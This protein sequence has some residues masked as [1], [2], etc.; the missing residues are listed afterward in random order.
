[1]FDSI[2]LSCHKNLVY[3]QVKIKKIKP[4]TLIE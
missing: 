1:L 2:I 3:L 4:T